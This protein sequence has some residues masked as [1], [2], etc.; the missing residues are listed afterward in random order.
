MSSKRVSA[1]IRWVFQL[2]DLPTNSSNISN[3]TIVSM[4]YA[5]SSR[6]ACA[7]EPLISTR[8]FCIIS[9][10]MFDCLTTCPQITDLQGSRLPGKISFNPI[11][12]KKEL[13][14]STE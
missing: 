3:W 12:K 8:S 14:L 10:D 4:M 6:P 11:V 1:G 2:A 13:K 9:K 7:P 5:F